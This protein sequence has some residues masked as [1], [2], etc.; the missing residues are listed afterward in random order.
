[1][2]KKTE[3][4]DL[5]I[6]A[7]DIECWERYPKHHWVYDLSR[8]LDTQHIKWSP[9]ETPELPDDTQNMY[10]D[11]S[12]P[13]IYHPSHIFIKEPEGN[14]AWTE[15]FII[16]GEI[17][18]IR[19]IKRVDRVYV[20]VTDLVGEIELRISAFVALHFQKF[21]GVISIQSVSTDI[22]SIR[23][24]P[25]SDLSVETNVDAVKL[26]KR[27]Y[28]KNDLS[29]YHGPGGRVFHESLTS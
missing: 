6:P 28:K 20:P 9:Y 19:H 21:T 16:K 15:V 13:I 2:Q 5:D 27:I 8:L 29:H 12:K 10:L 3:I 26:I 23:L 24:R 4:H 18:H 11:S 14:R 17:K 1:M 25:L 22:Y 7:C